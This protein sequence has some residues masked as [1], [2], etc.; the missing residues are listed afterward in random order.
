MKAIR[1][2]K[3]GSPEVMKLETVNELKPDK[4]Q[5]LVEIKA[6][7]VNPVETY[8]RAG[9]YARKPNLPYTPGG[10]AAGIVLAVGSEVAAFKAGDRVY[11]AGS[12]SGTY[13]EAALCAET[14]VHPLPANVS[15]NQGAALGIPYATAYRALFQRAYALQGETVLV[16]GASGGVGIAGIQL[17]L[18]ADLTIIASAGTE[19]GKALIMEQG[20][21]HVLDHA[22]AG[23]YEK[24]MMLTKGRGVDVILEML[25]NVNL[26]QDL[27][28]LALKGRVV[29]IG[30]RGNIE[31]DPRQ[32]MVHEANVMGMLLFN[33]GDDD[34]KAI[35]AGLAAGLIKGTLKPV[36]GKE[37]PLKDAPQ[38][39]KVVMAAG[40]Y[41]KIVL[42]P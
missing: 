35:H 30:S 42:I 34:L 36:I 12:I 20:S 5:V 17:A 27:N 22:D 3:F 29:V 25:A 8:I 14:Q 4:G 31:L 37:F 15:Y 1:I 26:A 18:A 23:H 33:A 41:G 21:N 11:T 19:K 16:H 7:G 24:I 39:H 40:A 13:A 6:A 32:L 10:D 9:M 2:N 28:I 38:A